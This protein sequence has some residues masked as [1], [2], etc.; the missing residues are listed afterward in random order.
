MTPDAQAKV[1]AIT[2][3]VDALMAQVLAAAERL[4]QKHA[5]EQQELLQMVADLIERDPDFRAAVVMLACD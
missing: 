1:D 3:P 4:A 5:A 2:A